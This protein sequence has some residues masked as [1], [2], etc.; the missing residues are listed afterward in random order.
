MVQ[1][2]EEGKGQLHRSVITIKGAGGVRVAEYSDRYEGEWK[3]EKVFEGEVSVVGKSG[4]REES[5]EVQEKAQAIVEDFNLIK[6]QTII[7]AF[8][9]IY[10]DAPNPQNF[11]GETGRKLDFEDKIEH[12]KQGSG[13]YNL[14]DGS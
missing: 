6:E 12:M 2:L 9:K 8:T 10:P 3:D 5:K 11:D 7:A 13:L 14:R 4:S 1:T